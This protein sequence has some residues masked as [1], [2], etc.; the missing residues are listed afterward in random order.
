MMLKINPDLQKS[1]ALI[2]MAKITLE[3][4]N[5]TDI[6]KYPSNTLTDYYD[7]IH[8]L[9]DSLALSKGIKFKGDGAH[10]ELIEYVCKTFTIGESKRI[11]LQE[12]RDFRNR[13]AYEGFMIK[14]EYIK[15]NIERIK[16][17]IGIL[18]KLLDVKIA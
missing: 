13:T 11:F 1:K 14:K 8:K 10:Q 15:S 3:R 6:Y 5:N 4:L 18:A 17:I 2:E 9:M 12:I 16:E 7:I